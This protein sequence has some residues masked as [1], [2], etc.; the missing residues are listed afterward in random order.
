[1][2]FRVLLAFFVLTAPALA[3][4]P[5][6][7]RERPPNIVVIMSDD[8]PDVEELAAMPTLRREMAWKGVTFKNSFVDFSLCCP[9]R[10][11]FLTGL[12]AHN[13]Q[14]FQNTAAED[15]GYLKFYSQGWE[16]HTLA[17]WLKQAGYR[18][19]F[20]GKYLNQY[21]V[22]AG[23]PWTHIPAGW[24]EWHTF[25]RGQVY[26]EYELNENGRIVPYGSN[27]ADYSTDVFSAQ[28]VDFIQRQATSSTP[29]FLVVAPLAPHN[30]RETVNG[31]VVP[32][33]A[34]R[35]QGKFSNWPFPR[36]PSFNEAN[37]RDKPGLVQSTPR[38]DR[39]GIQTIV[40]RYRLMRET[41][42]AVDEMIGA[43]LKAIDAAGKLDNTIVIFTSDNGYVHGEH[44]LLGKQYLYEPTI[45]V[46]L[47]MRGRG[48]P[49]GQIRQ[50]L[51]NNLDLAATIVAAAGAKPDHTLDGRSLT[52]LLRN[53][54]APWR[55]AMLVQGNDC[56]AVR[57][58]SQYA[59]VRTRRYMYGEH[60]TVTW[61]AEQELYD[62]NPNADPDQLVNV[63]GL[64]NYQDVMN[65]LQTV[66]ATL[67][68]CSGN[69]CWYTAPFVSSPT[70]ASSPRGRAPVHPGPV[71]NIF[72]T[73][74]NY[75][76]LQAL[77]P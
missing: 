13:H 33:P 7:A 34:V 55:T 69:G 71:K 16:D 12:A 1:M 37:V 67:K 10:T 75:D 15:G 24:D 30:G 61:G 77:D 18:T 68:T 70:K 21:P 52:P 5:A 17:L 59:A 73:R 26:Y 51:V 22:A 42:L 32:T 31:I 45:R 54:N 20:I 66:L 25:L 14:V 39:L 60:N 4:T 2:I 65:E 3:P 46:P 19:A 63:A 8:E 27:E 76:R 41:L 74:Q 36:T 43:V 35:H 62:M 47:I 11:S 6:S 9:S 53:A 57:N 44:R 56:D 50:Q 23:L 58:C 49:K 38:L 48:I 72:G 40:A 29:F 28:A 64:A